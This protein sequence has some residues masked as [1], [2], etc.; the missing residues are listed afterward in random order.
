MQ[1]RTERRSIELSVVDRLDPQ[2]QIHAERVTQQAMVCYNRHLTRGQGMVLHEQG[3][4]GRRND[5]IL[6]EISRTVKQFGA[7]L[8]ETDL[9][10]ESGRWKPKRDA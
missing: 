7:I 9:R 1:A 2:I 8:R 5:S 4:M 3:V 6:Q 10:Q